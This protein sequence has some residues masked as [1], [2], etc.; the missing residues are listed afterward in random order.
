MPRKAKPNQTKEITGFN[1]GLRS[2]YNSAPNNR[3]ALNNNDLTAHKVLL[4]V[5]LRSIYRSGIGSKIVRIK[6][7]YSLKNSIQF[8]NS[9]DEDLYKDILEEYVKK[10]VR[11]MIGFGRGVIV[12]YDHGEEME[13]PRRTPFDIKTVRMKAFSG[14]MITATNT[15]FD[16]MDQRY[17]MPT[18]YSIRGVRFHYTRVIDFSY[19]RPAEYDSPL[20]QFGGIS[21][22]ELVYN[23]LIN[24][25]VVE[26]ITPTILEKNSTLFYKVTGLA[27]AMEDKNDDNMRRYFNNL[28]NARSAYGAALLDAEDDAY[29]V[30]QTLTNLSEADTISLRRLAMVTGIPLAVLIGENVKGLNSTG[31]NEMQIFYEML[32][33][34]QEDYLKSPINQLF[35]KLGLDRIGFK[36]NQGKTSE[37]RIEYDAKALANAMVLAELGE[38]YKTY[39]RDRDVI[40]EDEFETFFPNAKEEEEID[41]S[42][43]IGDIIEANKT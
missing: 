4:P 34:L 27:N 20:Y 22:F 6:A 30:N 5:E 11:C 25:G 13:M 1:D 18:Y 2:I 39:L 32:E 19:V 23:Q 10:A 16:L 38:D 28:E 36:Q 42:Q 35:R 26:R 8:A 41:A 21:E 29:S 14:D 31:E 40:V 12:L 3:S 24:D 7:G 15:S 9:K 17:Y 43:T 33:A 37:Q